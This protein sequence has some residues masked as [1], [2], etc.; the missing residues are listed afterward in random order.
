M[1]YPAYPVGGGIVT[2]APHWTG[3]TNPLEIIP[4]GWVLDALEADELPN[5]RMCLV[6]MDYVYYQKYKPGSASV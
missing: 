5:S 1:G 4:N 3:L 2:P 6:R